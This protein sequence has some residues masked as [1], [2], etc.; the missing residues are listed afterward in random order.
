M[1]RDHKISIRF[2]SKTPLKKNI[3]CGMLPRTW[4][5]NCACPC[6]KGT[7]KKWFNQKLKKKKDK[8]GEIKWLPEASWLQVNSL[9]ENDRSS[10]QRLYFH[11]DLEKDLMTFLKEIILTTKP[12]KFSAREPGICIIR[13]IHIQTSTFSR[14]EITNSLNCADKLNVVAQNTAIWS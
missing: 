13:K 4:I 9:L 11:W 3:S 5:H 6:H 2:K 10:F 14:S 7:D 1:L 8:I 12:L